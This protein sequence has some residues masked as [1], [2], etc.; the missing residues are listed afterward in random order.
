M[1]NVLEMKGIRK[2]FF[3][4][5]VLH[6][7]DFCVEYGKV[8]ALLGE[9]GAGKST[10]VKIL[11]GV[12]TASA[13]EIHYNGAK[14]SFQSTMHALANGISMIHQEIAAIP[15]MTVAEN[16]FLGREPSKLS[17]IRKKEQSRI[18]RDLLEELGININP[19]T[20]AKN[21]SVSEMQ[22]MDIAKAISYNSN[23]IIMDEPTSSLTNVEIK[24]LFEAIR[25]LTSRG[26]SIIYITHKLEE[27]FEIADHVTVLRDGDLISSNPIST[28]TREKI[29]SDM[30][31]R[32]LDE[33]YP[34]SE[35]EIGQTALKVSGLNRKNVFQDISFEIR[36]GEVLGFA[37]M[38]GSGRTET[39]NAIF[40]IDAIDDGEIFLNGKK[41]RIDKPNKAIANKIAFIPEDRRT[42]GLNTKKTVRDNICALVLSKLSRGGFITKRIERNTALP[43]VDQ[44][45]IKI[46]ST[47]QLV[48]SLSGG[49]QQKV[50]IAKWLLSE[51]DIIFMDEPTRG[52]DVGA[53]HEIY[54]LVLELAKSGK[55]VLFV[56]SEM[57]ELLGVCDKIMVFR[58]GSI[59]SELNAKEATQEMIMEIIS[60]KITSK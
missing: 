54:K 22:L 30:V 25:K 19:D 50:V 5:E 47:E 13:G 11:M 4:V 37:G 15:E 48:S 9:N 43:M 35:K 23:I 6:G 31:G 36:K 2:H 1:S 12:H 39:L 41:V 27:L 32:S 8:T 42:C 45:R 60:S 53:K 52:I 58:E 24:V 20:K 16:I 44:L 28:I 29:I 18:T 51:P 21:L 56:S 7:V 34:V 26:V 33:V 3:G 59:A 17:Y 49:N 55:A 14:I 46:A 10:L 57:P 38:V 40:G